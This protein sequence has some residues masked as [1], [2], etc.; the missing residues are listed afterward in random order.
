MGGA[1]FC[2]EQ[3][4]NKKDSQSLQSNKDEEDILHNLS[5]KWILRHNKEDT[6]HPGDAQARKQDYGGL[7]KDAEE[8]E[9]KE[10]NK[11]EEEEE[12]EGDQ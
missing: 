8:E 7:Q 9:E 11:A 6:K 2:V 1:H 3:A 12:E 5:V 10:D 4:V